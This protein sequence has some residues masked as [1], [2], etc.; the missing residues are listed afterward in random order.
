[1]KILYVTRVP[2]T[3]THFIF[4]LAKKLRERGNIVEFAFGPGLGLKDVVES[5]FP[6]TMLS[7]DKMSRSFENI[8][9]YQSTE[10]G[11]K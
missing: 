10:Q 3:A 9:S 11:Y 5:S 1:M 8:P 7:M 4:P 2:T 6:F